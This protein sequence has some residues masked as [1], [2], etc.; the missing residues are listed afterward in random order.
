L[1]T[2]LGISY[3]IVKKYLGDY[4]FLKI[5]KVPKEENP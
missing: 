4:M 3:P 2:K 1:K 5:E